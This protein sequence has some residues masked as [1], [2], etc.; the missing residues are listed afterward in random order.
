MQPKNLNFNLFQ[1]K[2]DDININKNENI[3]NISL[4]RLKTY[5]QNSFELNKEKNL[6]TESKLK[7]ERNSS[8]L[9]CASKILDESAN[10]NI[11]KQKE[12]I[13]FNSFINLKQI[14]EK[15]FQI[16]SSYENINKLSNDN[17]IK[18][19]ELQLKIKNLLSFQKNE[20]N[21]I[22]KVTYFNFP[23]TIINI[24]KKTSFKTL[25]CENGDLTQKNLRKFTP[26]NTPLNDNNDDKS[27]RFNSSKRI[28][29]FSGVLNDDN[30]NKSPNNLQKKSN[31]NQPKKKTCKIN[32]QLNI[33]T[34]NIENTNKNINNPELFYSNFFKNIINKGN[35]TNKLGKVESKSKTNIFKYYLKDKEGSVNKKS[36]NE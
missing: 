22:G 21:N 34:K 28:L 9:V 1:I 8:I 3:K 17:Y 14:K 26:L 20:T 18:N 7:E 36:N 19:P 16:N 15:N 31:R 23:K 27:Q 10:F 30:A 24:N 12:K 25:F 2:N 29:N 32:K 11:N 35:S 6:K 4:S 33:I 13:I 5:F